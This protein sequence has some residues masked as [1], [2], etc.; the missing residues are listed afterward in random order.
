MADP[1]GSKFTQVLIIENR[2]AIKCKCVADKLTL[3]RKKVG[4]R[5]S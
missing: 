4:E 1:I 5:Y 2:K 3:V